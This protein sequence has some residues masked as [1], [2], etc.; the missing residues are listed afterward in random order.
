MIIVAG[1]A[2]RLSDAAATSYPS[3]QEL[4]CS[5]W[6]SR[7]QLI[8]NS[9]PAR[10]C[11]AGIGTRHPPAGYAAACTGGLMSHNVFNVLRESGYGDRCGRSIPCPP[12]TAPD[13][14]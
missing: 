6:S 4:S 13:R 12:R 2:A 11:A 7:A 5:T 8:V 9:L 14:E 3:F 10:C 1:L